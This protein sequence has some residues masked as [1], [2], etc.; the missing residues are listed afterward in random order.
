MLL[1]D[2]AIYMFYHMIPASLNLHSHGKVYLVQPDVL[3]YETRMHD[4]L[5]YLDVT[6]ST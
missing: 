3:K 1:Y 4:V 2:V 5:I 6:I